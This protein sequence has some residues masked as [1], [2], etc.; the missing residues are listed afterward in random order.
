MKY[1]NFSVNDYVKSSIQILSQ[2]QKLGKCEEIL[3]MIYI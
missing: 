1:N 3:K 2:I